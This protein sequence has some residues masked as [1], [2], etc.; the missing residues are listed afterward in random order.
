MGGTTISRTGKD[1][2][3]LINEMKD[4]IAEASHIMS[5]DSN[6]ILYKP[7]TKESKT[8]KVFVDPESGNVEF[9]EQAGDVISQRGDGIAIEVAANFGPKP[10]E[11]EWIAT[12]HLH[13]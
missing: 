7:S 8:F 13:T 5:P 3:V 4:Q 10:K 11:D 1:I 9:V 2:N 12:V 6:L